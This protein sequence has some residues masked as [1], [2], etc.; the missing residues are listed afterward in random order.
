MWRRRSFAIHHGGPAYAEYMTDEHEDAG[1][2][3]TSPERVETDEDRIRASFEEMFRPTKGNVLRAAAAGASREDADDA[4]PQVLQEALVMFALGNFSAAFVQALGQRA[5]D[6][7]AKRMGDLVQKRLPRKGKP[8]ECRIGVE[9]GSAA[10]IAITA[11]TPDEA[12]LAL[13]DLDVTAEEVRGKTMRWD[14][15]VMAWR[16]YSADD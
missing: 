15:D 3:T 13:L 14:N 16:A 11:D 8:D 9:D 12:R 6:G 7:A 2:K 4:A 10:T 1:S 5:A